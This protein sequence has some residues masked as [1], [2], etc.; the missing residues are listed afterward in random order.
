MIHPITM[1]ELIDRLKECETF[2]LTSHVNPDGDA[3]GSEYTLA[4]ALRGLGKRVRIINT[5]DV[6]I[7]L[8]FLSERLDYESYDEEKHRSAL[9][10][11][12][13]IV[14]LDANSA[15]RLK[16]MESAVLSS[17]AKKLVID[18]H[19]DPLPFA[20]GYFIREDASSTAEIVYDI[21]ESAGWELTS[22]IALG[23]YT[24]MMT[25]TGS[26]RFER[27]TPRVHRIAAKLLEAGV[28][29]TATYQKIFDEFPARR[30]ILLGRI[31][32]GMESI[33]NGAGVLM[34]VTKAMF[35][36]TGCTIDETDNIVNQGLAIG[37]V[38]VSALFIEQEDGIKISLRS[39]NGRTVSD[40]AR[41]LGG[42]GHAFAAGA[43]IKGQSLD[44]V[45]EVVRKELEELLFGEEEKRKSQIANPKSVISNP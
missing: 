18:H 30:T 37:G 17:P 10:Q 20:D 8:R 31:L 22:D 23:I 29:P 15:S 40:I 11:V 12:D 45:R 39:R 3:L 36:E 1:D 34:T 44:E 32:A 6:P 14:I 19:L 43:F 35:E 42:G 25:D 38:S 21:C 16:T 33:A 24:G 9:D 26:F 13:A 4:F 2:V 27:T 41:R 28:D 7:N 5:S